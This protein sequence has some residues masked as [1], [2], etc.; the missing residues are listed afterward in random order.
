MF[1]ST[2]INIQ[3]SAAMGGFVQIKPSKL[4]HGVGMNNSY[5]ANQAVSMPSV[6]LCG[7]MP[8]RSVNKHSRFSTSLILTCYNIRKLPSSTG[9]ISFKLININSINNGAEVCGL[10][11]VDASVQGYGSTAT[12]DSRGCFKNSSCG[13]I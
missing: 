1:L 3:A 8:M 13:C 4:V 2:C 7:Q 11:I 9:N 6:L 12:F 10:Q 5:H